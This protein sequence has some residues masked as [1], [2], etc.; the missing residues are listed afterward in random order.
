MSKEIQTDPK[1][2][3]NLNLIKS[4]FAGNDELL[5][6]IRSLLIGQPTSEEDRNLI[7]EVFKNEDLI[8]IVKN[9]IFQ[10][11]TDDI[12]VGELND[13]WMGAD[14]IAGQPEEVIQQALIYRMKVLK[15]FRNVSV[16]LR[17]P[18]LKVEI[19][20]MPSDEKSLVWSQRPD[21]DLLARNLYIKTIDTG[22]FMLKI[23]AGEKSETPE[24]Q[25]KRL[26]KDSSQ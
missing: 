24:E 17:N 7:R 14:R 18:E 5:K 11:I 1:T 9:K 4:T 19:F 8:T 23:I 13:F 3:K 6:K 25:A 15:M 10:E 26:F 21:C 20:E 16:I 12:P 2:E 22:L